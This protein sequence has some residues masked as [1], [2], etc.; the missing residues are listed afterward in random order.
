MLQSSNN[1]YA[2]TAP[3]LTEVLPILDKLEDL[4]DQYAMTPLDSNA[5][6]LAGRRQGFVNMGKTEYRATADEVVDASRITVMETAHDNG[7]APKDTVLQCVHPGLELQ[8]S[9]I[10]PCL[11][12]S[13]GVPPKHDGAVAATT[14]DETERSYTLEKNCSNSEL[15]VLTHK[16]APLGGNQSLDEGCIDRSCCGILDAVENHAQVAVHSGSRNWRSMLDV[17][18]NSIKVAVH[19]GSRNCCKFG[20]ILEYREQQRRRCCATGG[21]HVKNRRHLYAVWEQAAV[22]ET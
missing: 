11:V 21:L 10:R 9:V 7:S 22:R 16:L 18:D 13:L 17:V 14:M 3:V 2:S 8:C 5:K 4:R 15:V 19:S 1:K 12:A 20:R 6:C